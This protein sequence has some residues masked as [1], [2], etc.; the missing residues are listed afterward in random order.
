MPTASRREHILIELFLS[1]YESNSW[2]HCHRDWLEKKKDGAVEILANRSDGKTLAIEHTLIQPFVE[3]KKD[4]AHFK[5]FLRIEADKSLIIPERIIYVYVPA[6]ALQKDYSWDSVV[7][8]AHKWLKAN[9]VSL[10]EGISQQTC[11]IIDIRK[12]KASDLNLQVKVIFA[13]GFEGA[14]MIRRYGEE[15]LGEAVQK[16][17]EEKLPKL[18]KTEADKRILL[19]ER[20][21]FTLSELSIY[22][23]IEERRAMFP[24]LAKVHEVWF[25]ETVFYE[26]NK[27]VRFE[28]YDSRTLVQSLGFLDGRLIERSENGMPSSDVHILP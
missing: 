7:T 8:T 11:P 26:I 17:L 1:S 9:I 22:D 19:L 5:H 23:V 13:P 20:D 10:P 25:A 27:Y 14:F 2:A 28:L 24:D 12:R 3:D 18:V 4:F 15:S 16:A 21:Q 6:E